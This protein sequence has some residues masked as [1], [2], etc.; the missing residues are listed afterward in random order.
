[1]QPSI[2]VCCV[3]AAFFAVAVSAQTTSNPSCSSVNT[4]D[5]CLLA[6]SQCAFCPTLGVC[7]TW[8]PC[9]DMPSA[10]KY[11]NTLCSGP[12][13][14]GLVSHGGWLLPH[15]R[16]KCDDEKAIGFYIL[17][18]TSCMLVVGLV[19]AVVTM[20]DWLRSKAAFICDLLLNRKYERVV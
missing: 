3:I 13:T 8:D 4:E 5:D 15:D 19:L 17:I 6:G 2:L 12:E 9:A 18:C 14:T 20:F 10:G 16:F 1:M 7:V 11:H